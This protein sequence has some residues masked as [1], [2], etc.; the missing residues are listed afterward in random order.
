MDDTLRVHAVDLINA[1]WGMYLLNETLAETVGALVNELDEQ[2][3]MAGDDDA[4][5]AFAKLY[6]S[7]AKT[8]VNQ[9]GEATNIMGRG[10][11]TTLKAANDFMAH[12]SQVA[13]DMLRA[14]GQIGTSL[15]GDAASSPDCTPPPRNRGEDLPEVVGETGAVTQY[16]VGDRFRGSPE[17][18]RAVAGTWRKAKS[19]AE[20]VL[21]DAQDA[22]R[23]ATSHANGQTADAV[24]AFFTEFVG[25]DHPPG[26]VDENCSLLANLP[27]ACSQ[28]A[29][30]CENYADHI[31]TASHRASKD[32]MK[33]LFDKS[34]I[35]NLLDSPTFGGNGE[36]GGLHAAVSSDDHI[37]DLASVG[38]T[39]DSTQARV[40]IPN[41]S[42]DAPPLPGMP[43][44]PPLRIPLTDIPIPELIPASY[45]P[46]SGNIPRAPAIAPP[47]PPDPRFPPLTPTQ[48]AQ[49]QQ[50][51]SGL[52]EGDVSGGFPE[53]VQYQLRVA[54]YPEYEVPIPPGISKRDDTLMVDGMRP[55]DGMAI[56]AKHV[57]NPQKCPRT[58]DAIRESHTTGKR[59]FLY[60]KDR[61]ELRKYAAA[62]N[63]P[64]NTEL[65]G[66]EID[67]DYQPSVP[68]WRSMMV[69]Y[70][71]NGYARYVP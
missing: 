18:L 64:R 44:L 52:R 47:V 11:E 55:T 32:A 49:F 51:L 39:L 14:M 19:I 38:H 28:L 48:R 40:P 12:D 35:D 42:G 71:V 57:R 6:N 25:K 63:D 1:S 41:P 33:D 65:R 26:R 68:Y 50:W 59:D 21:S 36:D 45:N 46:P 66:V 4:G 5:H 58:L 70:G 37:L 15:A 60:A 34:V 9:L 7:A 54:G 29:K 24:N 62:L 20:G 30:A 67:T 10:S 27:T 23:T 53:D 31:Q 56:E 61:E 43:L 22:W 17:K 13:A 16:V 3:G 69:A 8:T 2:H